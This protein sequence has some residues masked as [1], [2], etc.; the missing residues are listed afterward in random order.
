MAL[1]KLINSVK[2]FIAG[3]AVAVAVNGCASS[4]RHERW[5]A[6]AAKYA[7][8]LNMAA[9]YFGG[10]GTHEG[11]HALTAALLGGNSIEVSVLPSRHDGSFLFGYT[12]FERTKP[13][14][15][16][17][18]SVLNI[19][20]P[21]INLVA[22][23]AAREI[24][25]SGEVPAL[26]QPTLQWYAIGNKGAFYWNCI[27]GIAGV[28]TADLGKEELWVPITMLFAGLTYDVFDIFVDDSPS[29]YL[30]VLFGESFYGTDDANVSME[31][32]SSRDTQYLGVRINW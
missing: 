5:E 2:N 17:E 26:I 24:L 8:P 21:G 31:L 20:G 6:D 28:K 22:G 3:I 25:K 14:R 30:E 19:S 9:S 12:S 1:E 13:L 29:R 7:I 16:W 10:L 23:I 11:G 27:K 18:E 32:S 4:Q 15:E